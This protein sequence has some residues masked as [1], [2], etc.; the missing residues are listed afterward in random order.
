MKEKH[1]V[2]SI[3]TFHE[4]HESNISLQISYTTK[5]RIVRNDDNEKK[6]NESK[7]QNKQT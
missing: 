2:Q 5:F 6:V 4:L 3:I 7:K 1:P